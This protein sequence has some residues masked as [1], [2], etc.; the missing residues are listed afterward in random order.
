[1]QGSVTMCELWG[2]GDDLNALQMS[3]RAVAMFWILLALVRLGG[4]RMFGKK[5][6]F[7][8]VVAMTLGAIAARGIIGVSPFG[9]TVAACAVMVALH[10]LAAWVAVKSGGLNRVLKG[11]PTCL[12]SQGQIHRDALLRTTISE[13]DLYESLRLETRQRDLDGIEEANLEA[14]GR[15][16]FI[17]KR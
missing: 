1:M 13:A 14:N 5:S 6:S 17:E 3:V 2:N 16:S 4:A 15:I 11:R 7:D 8:I 9:A 12:Y 10:R